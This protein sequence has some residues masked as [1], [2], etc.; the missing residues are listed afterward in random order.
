RGTGTRARQPQPRRTLPSLEVLEDR[1]VPSLFGPPS[2]VPTGTS[3]GRVVVG[4]FNEDGHLD[5]VVA[6]YGPSALTPGSVTVHL[7]DG[8]GTG[9]HPPVVGPASYPV[10]GRNPTDMVAADFNGDGPLDLAVCTP[11]S[12]QVT[13]LWGDGD[14]SFDGRPGLPFAS[15]G[16]LPG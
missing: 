5:F 6:A 12:N 13:V 14:G 16:T 1:T 10:F 3:P 9:F 2:P 4:D 8:T 11:D 15:G 7:N